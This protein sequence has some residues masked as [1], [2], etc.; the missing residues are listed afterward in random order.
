MVSIHL[1]VNSGQG[2][3]H[4]PSSAPSSPT[5]FWSGWACLV[6]FVPN[7][8]QSSD[9]EGAPTPLSSSGPGAPLHVH[10]RT[11]HARVPLACLL[12]QGVCGVGGCV[13][14]GEDLGKVLGIPMLLVPVFFCSGLDRLPLPTNPPPTLPLTS[15]FA[16]PSPWL[17]HLSHCC[18]AGACRPW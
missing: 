7:H 17:H 5:L 15:W 6:L 12:G 4:A 14:A 13:C 9:G 10:V 8:S 16:P 1:G 3:T 18:C 11:A 2:D